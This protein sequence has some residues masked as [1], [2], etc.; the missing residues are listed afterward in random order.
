M[1]YEVQLVEFVQKLRALNLKAGKSLIVGAANHLIKGTELADLFKD[2]Q[3][4]YA[5]YYSFRNRYG[6]KMKNQVRLEMDRKRWTTSDHFCSWYEVVMDGMI[7]CG[8]AVKTDS[9]KDSEPCDIMFYVTDP[10]M[11]FEW[12]QTGFTLD[13]TDD[14]KGPTEKTMTVDSDDDGTCVVNKSSVRWTLT[15][16]SIMN[17]DALPGCATPPSKSMHL[18][19][20]K[21]P[22]RSNLVDPETGD[23]RPC[24][25]YPHPSEVVLDTSCLQFQQNARIESHSDPSDSS[26]SGN[27]DS[28]A[29][30]D[31]LRLGGEDFRL[32]PLT[33]GAGRAKLE[34]RQKRKEEQETLRKEREATKNAKEQQKCEDRQLAAKDA[35][36][37][38]W[39][40]HHQGLA[41]ALG[42]LQKKHLSALLILTKSPVKG[43]ETHGVLASHL[44]NKLKSDDLEKQDKNIRELV[45]LFYEIPVSCSPASAS[46]TTTISSLPSPAATMSPSASP[47]T[48]FWPRSASTPLPRATVAAS[49]RP[50]FLMQPRLPRPSNYSGPRLPTGYAAR[51]TPR[52]NP[53][54]STGSS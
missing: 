20:M 50:A 8:I 54:S 39:S 12:D 40:H 4:T 47:G 45:N 32:G 33:Y 30:V 22:P 1:R 31:S 16:G 53:P 48:S 25:F 27:S 15:G 29:N 24:Q 23:R 18:S 36:K 10:D 19:L 37:L 49:P 44:E 26:D 51:P 38:L 41:H 7:Q 35:A 5:W 43:N 42:K 34:E 9:F 28:D 21:D 17:G 6:I 52:G 46:T 2:K 13:Q 11:V 14:G 3:V